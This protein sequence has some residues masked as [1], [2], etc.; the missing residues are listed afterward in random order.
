MIPMDMA[1]ELAGRSGFNAWELFYLEKRIHLVKAANGK[2]SSRLSASEKGI[3][4]RA[5]QHGRS[6]SASTTD[7]TEQ[8]LSAMLS[9]L[10]ESV[11]AGSPDPWFALPSPRSDGP[12][13]TPD[14][15]VGDSPAWDESAVATRVLE[16]ES[17]ARRTDPRIRSVSNCYQRVSTGLVAVRNS[18]GVDVS[19]DFSRASLLVECSAEERGVLKTSSFGLFGSDPSKLD[20]AAVGSEAGRRAAAALKAKGLVGG[21][22]NVVLSPES[23]AHVLS[24]LAPYLN[25]SQVADALS[26]WKDLV[27]DAVGTAEATLIDEPSLQGSYGFARW[28]AEGNPTEPLTLVEKGIL[29]GFAHSCETAAR[30]ASRSTGHAVRT[31]YAFPPGVGFHNLHLAC[32]DR[33]AEDV[34]GEAGEGLYVEDLWSQP[35]TGLR[36]GLFTFNVR[37]RTIRSGALS[38]P[39]EG[40]AISESLPRL[41]LK[42]RMAGKDLAWGP[43]GTAGSTTLLEKIT[44][45]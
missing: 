40:A 2:T 36:N 16:A 35:G 10:S 33:E 3:G 8:G 6:A 12:D 23:A 32:S 43:R 27:G 19:F 41:L 22:Y 44:V 1:T 11:L 21:R 18:K 28:D 38:D 14:A 15:Q 13:R 31:D 25:G 17:A 26:P 37:G 45:C 30:S 5:S 42:L 34:I 29:K 20:P 4:A 24:R 9:R 7:L 39:I